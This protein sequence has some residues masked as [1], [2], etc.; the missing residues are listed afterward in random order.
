MAEN[1]H[2]DESAE[3]LNWILSANLVL[4]PTLFGYEL[5]VFLSFCF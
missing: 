2:I 4:S 1:L 3:S 5:Y